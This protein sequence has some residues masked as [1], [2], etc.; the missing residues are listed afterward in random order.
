MSDKV[1]IALIIAAALVIVVYL[2]RARLSK[3]RIKADGQ[4]VEGQLE[5]GAP[6]DGAAPA[7][8]PGVVVR[9]T[10]MTGKR[11]KVTVRRG[12]AELTDN[13]MRGTDQ[14]ITVDE[15]SAE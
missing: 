6:A 13:V 2:L 3:L 1:L 5:A 9:G 14:K 10:W 4:S 7:S 12:D 15:G 8:H 11:Q